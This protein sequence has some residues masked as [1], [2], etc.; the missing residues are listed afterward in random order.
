MHWFKKCPCLL[1]LI[2]FH[3]TLDFGPH[4]G[5]HSFL[6]L[7]LADGCIDV[8]D[9]SDSLESLDSAVQEAEPPMKQVRESV[10]GSMRS[11]VSDIVSVV[12]G[13]EEPDNATHPLSL[14]SPGA[15]G[16]IKFVRLAYFAQLLLET[17]AVRCI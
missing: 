11:S 15:V 5:R 6:A 17:G 14:H 4:C 10:R 7:L 8:C 16:N 1:G 12:F 13:N 3:C 2:C 9:D